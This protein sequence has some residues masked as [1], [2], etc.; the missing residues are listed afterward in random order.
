MA[1]TAVLPT[2][3]KLVVHVAVYGLVELSVDVHNVPEPLA[4]VTMPVGVAAPGALG[5]TVAVKVTV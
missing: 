5:A 4:K 2:L 3:A 1:V